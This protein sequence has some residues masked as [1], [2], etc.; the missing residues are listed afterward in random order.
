[1]QSETH[2]S[3][4]LE[5]GMP[6]NPTDPQAPATEL[7]SGSLV[8]DTQPAVSRP[9][10]RAL[11]GSRYT[12]QQIERGLVALALFSGNRRRASKALEQ[13]GL[14]IPDSTLRDWRETY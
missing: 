3:N 6:S 2:P 10:K 13:Q 14:S 7:Q 9:Q 8:G 11:P 4:K 5:P 1:M 12:D